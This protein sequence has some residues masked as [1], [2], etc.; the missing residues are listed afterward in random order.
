MTAPTDPAVPDELTKVD[1]STLYNH[2]R[3]MMMLVLGQYESWLKKRTT[4][5]VEFEH[6]KQ[7][8]EEIRENMSR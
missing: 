7:F 3:R 4:R 8:T 2:D 6:L 5:A 1:W